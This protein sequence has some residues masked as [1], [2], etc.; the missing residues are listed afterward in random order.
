MIINKSRVKIELEK[1]KVLVTIKHD[2]KY[3]ITKINSLTL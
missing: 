1:Q 2:K 3:F